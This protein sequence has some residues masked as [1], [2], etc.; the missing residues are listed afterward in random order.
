M[1]IAMHIA[2]LQKPCGAAVDLRTNTGLV[3]YDGE[4]VWAVEPGGEAMLLEAR[5][6][7]ISALYLHSPRRRVRVYLPPHRLR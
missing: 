6:R 7:R 5:A 2:T 1:C 4:A 3:P